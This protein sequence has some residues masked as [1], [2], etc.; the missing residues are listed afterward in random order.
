MNRSST[1][2]RFS[3]W[4][5]DWD[6]DVVAP[7][8]AILDWVQEMLNSSSLRWDDCQ[9]VD[10]A[11]GIRVEALA[12]VGRRDRLK[13][14]KAA[15]T[16]RH[17]LLLILGRQPGPM[18]RAFSQME[19]SLPGEAQLEEPPW[20]VLPEAIPDLVAHIERAGGCTMFGHDG[21]FMLTAQPAEL[22]DADH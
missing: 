20:D 12:P 13:W 14:L 1:L 18:R 3:S 17:S 21:Q 22:E 6:S 4:E 7:L 19:M 5:Y 2:L 16:R 15:L 9:F 8:E 11:G 10:T